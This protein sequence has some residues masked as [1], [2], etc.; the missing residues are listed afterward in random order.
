MLIVHPIAVPALAA[1]FVAQLCSRG[2]YGVVPSTSLEVALTE[3]FVAARVAWPAGSFAADAYVSWLADKVIDHDGPIEEVLDRL[4]AEDLYLAA[5]C[6]RGDPVAVAALHDAHFGDLDAVLRRFG[7]DAAAADDV[8]QQ[9]LELLFIGGDRGPRIVRYSGRGDLRS[10]LRSITVRTAHRALARLRRDRGVSDTGS[11]AMHEDV[12]G[13]DDPALAH[14][15]RA[16][17]A[18][19]SAALREA[20]ARLSRRQRLLL[21]RHFVDGRSLD[22]LGRRYRVHRSTAARRLRAA[23]DALADE[24]R[25]RLTQAI[26]V[27]DADLAD[28]VRL[29]QNQLDLD[30]SRVLC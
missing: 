7:A 25:R 3:R 26:G 9:V 14:L 1:T 19:L 30:L 10:W 6:S 29:V 28:I 23:R 15:K 22:E 21:R 13:D 20:C 17:A 5:A 11:V 24:T 2:R 27:D 8:K 18:P 12:D 16:Y 4:H